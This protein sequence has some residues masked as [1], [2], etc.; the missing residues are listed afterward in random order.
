MAGKGDKWRKTDYKK[1]YEN[2]D[3]IKKKDPKNSKMK[4]IT[5]KGGRVRYVL[6]KD[7]E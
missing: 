2:A 1:F 5:L 7:N 4:K 3:E 6:K